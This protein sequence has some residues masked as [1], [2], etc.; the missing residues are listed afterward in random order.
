MAY[1]LSM[2]RV[3]DHYELIAFPYGISDSA[4]E[5]ILT[6]GSL[7]EVIDISNALMLEQFGPGWEVDVIVPE[8]FLDLKRIHVHSKV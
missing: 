4:T 7:E 8:E 5:T 1:R 2:R 3:E 6:R